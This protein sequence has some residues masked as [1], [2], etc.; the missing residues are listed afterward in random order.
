MSSLANAMNHSTATSTWAVQ[1]AKAHFSEMLNACRH[2]QPQIITKRG[3]QVAV[4]VPFDWWQ[5]IQSL[6]RP[7]LKALLLADDDRFD[8]DLPERTA[9]NSR[10][11]IDFS[12][13]DYA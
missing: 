2:Q 8:L 4:L 9:F 11:P 13:D 6:H 7:S 5:H 1:D 10:E 3:E 12:G